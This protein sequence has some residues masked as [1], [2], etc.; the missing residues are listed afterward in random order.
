MIQEQWGESKCWKISSNK[1]QKLVGVLTENILIF[2]KDI[3][4]S[5]ANQ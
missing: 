3:N 4:N 2:E 5:C 1:L